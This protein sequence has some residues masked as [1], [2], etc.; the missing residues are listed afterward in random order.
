MGRPK[1]NMTL[2]ER[3]AHDTK[4]A[5]L[6]QK[7]HRAKKRSAKELEGQL[8]KE[9]LDEL[10][11]MLWAMPLYKASL[12]LAEIQRNYKKQYGIEIP[13]LQ[14]ATRVGYKTEGETQEEYTH[15]YKRAHK[16]GLARMFSTNSIQRFKA[17]ARNKKY[18]L[19]EANE[20]AA[21][22]ISNQAYKELKREFKMATCS[23]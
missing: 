17:N 18:A 9:Q 13:G 22:G 14:E 23:T 4:G 7:K 15:R 20:A 21:L 16:F 1:L 10:I 19:K 5:N 3:K 11:D 2:E 8:T 6:R 12:T